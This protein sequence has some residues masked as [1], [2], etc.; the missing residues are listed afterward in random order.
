MEGI[1]QNGKLKTEQMN[2]WKFKNFIYHWNNIV[3]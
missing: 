1:D 3:C 2:K